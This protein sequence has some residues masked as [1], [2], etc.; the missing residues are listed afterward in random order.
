MDKDTIY[1]ELEF[2]VGILKKHLYSKDV[3]SGYPMPLA[4]K[5]KQV[6]KW[7]VILD[8]VHHIMVED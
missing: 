3:L 5:L 6:K 8:E 2:I 7:Y 1:E 4:L